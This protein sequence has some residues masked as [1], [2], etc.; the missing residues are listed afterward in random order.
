MSVLHIVLV[1][2]KPTVSPLEIQQALQD[3]ENL[4]EIP[5]VKSVKHG[6][7][8]STRNKG[9]THAFVV[10]MESKEQVQEYDQHEL[11][12]AYSAKLRS[13]VQDILAIDFE[14]ESIGS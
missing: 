9:F 14:N 12:I 3:L 4:T 8:F 11:H 7:N 6:E 10:E 5:F 2:F 1:S 13:A